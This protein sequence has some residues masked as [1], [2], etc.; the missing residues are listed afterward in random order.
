MFLHK[1]S[2]RAPV[3]RLKKEIK[4]D[5][6]AKSEDLLGSSCVEKDGNRLISRYKR[7]EM[8]LLSKAVQV[9]NSNNN[10]IY[11]LCDDGI[12]TVLGSVLEWLEDTT[13]TAM[14]S[15]VYRGDV[16]LSAKGFGTYF[17]T[18]SVALKVYDD[19]FASMTVCADRIFGLQDNEIRYTAAGE[20]D[21]WGNGQK[22]T[23]PT[24]CDALVTLGE[25][26]YALGNTCYTLEPKADDIDFKL[27]VFANNMGAVA[28]RSTV[29]YNG[30]VV[31][32]TSKGLYQISSNK[33]TPI[34][35]HLYDTIDFTNCAGTL[36]D[37]KYYLCCR[38]RNSGA[39]DPDLTLILDLD[40]EEI[41][42]V[43]DIGYDSITAV[44]N[45][46]VFT[47][48][49][50]CYWVDYT[51]I[52]GRFVKNNVNFATDKKK[53]LDRL[54]VTTRNDLDVTIRSE[55]ETR[56]Y[57]IKGK[58]TAQKINLRD[59]GWEFSIELSSP[60]GLDVENLAIDAHVCGE[61]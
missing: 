54:T 30:R 33:I 44:S 31:F 53:F 7:R 1:K 2:A 6:D 26:V 14:S 40:R 24:A 43:L 16:I 38:S 17:A 46:I 55:T 29:A 5:F 49:G 50:H 28:A 34:F 9:V 56:L 11:I 21:G 23:L 52:G 60:D 15:C 41:L 45:R 4:L 48:Q 58:K 32:G 8:Y 51:A 47:R 13:V 3:K 35:T 18:K 27:S 61:V 22:I 10:V 37:G 12:Y 36:Y 25:K 39:T 42:G 59:M 19:G 57:K 20:R